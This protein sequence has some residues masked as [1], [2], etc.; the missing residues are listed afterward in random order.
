MDVNRAGWI[1]LDVCR[2]SFSCASPSVTSALL[3]CRLTS[4]DLRKSNFSDVMLLSHLR[5]L[6]LLVMGEDADAPP[7]L[8]PLALQAPP[9]FTVLRDDAGYLGCSFKHSNLKHMC[10]RHAQRA[11]SGPSQLA[12]PGVPEM[13]D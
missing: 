9:A 8:A 2:S 12:V 4:L 3:V 10:D 7:S 5:E 13:A 6:R 11:N 1:T